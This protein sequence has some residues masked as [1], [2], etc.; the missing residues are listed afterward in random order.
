MSS[1][2]LISRG[3][4]ILIPLASSQQNLYEICLLLCIQYQTPD[5]GQKTCLKHVE[6]Y[7]K[8][9][10]EKLVHLVGFIIR[11]VHHCYGETC[12]FC[13]HSRN[14]KV[15]AAGFSKFTVRAYMTIHLEDHNIKINFCFPF[16][17]QIITNRKQEK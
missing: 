11:R 2:F 6:L 13:L 3:P 1:P 5:D 15:E 7:S 4:C 14:L 8:N 17:H 9:K 12:C 16:E 10:F